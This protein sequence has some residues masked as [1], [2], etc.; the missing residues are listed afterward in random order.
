[1]CHHG[2]GRHIRIVTQGR[3]T[4]YEGGGGVTPGGSDAISERGMYYIRENVALG[5]RIINGKF[6]IATRC[7]D[8]TPGTRL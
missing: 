7:R 8:L 5:S 4:L 3:G 2:E 1:M 6:Y